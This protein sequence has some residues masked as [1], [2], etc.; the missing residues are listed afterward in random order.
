[1]QGRIWSDDLRDVAEEDTM[2]PNI[3]YL[4]MY[5]AGCQH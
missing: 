5:S 2:V 1:M 3:A 4:P